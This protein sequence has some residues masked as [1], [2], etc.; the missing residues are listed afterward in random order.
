MRPKFTKLFFSVRMLTAVL[1]LG[2]L[3]FLLIESFPWVMRHEST[4]PT[5][6]T[7]LDPQQN[8]VSGANSS[9]G[10]AQTPSQSPMS[11]PAP[12]GVLTPAA[13]TP[14][15]A[16][17]PPG[18]TPTAGPTPPSTPTPAAVPTP[19]ATPTPA[20]VPT[21]PS[22]PTPAALPTPRSIPAA[23]EVPTPSSGAATTSQPIKPLG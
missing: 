17:A 10:A 9:L 13:P 11:A 7:T 22:V 19:P 6:A 4:L 12:G 2:G 21:P 20:A 5:L 1:L 3:G 18:P 8:A 23:S 15:P 14:N 16:P